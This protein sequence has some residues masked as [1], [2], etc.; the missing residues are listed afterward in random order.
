MVDYRELYE[1][2]VE[3]IGREYEIH[4]INCDHTDNDIDNLVM[5][6]RELHHRW[7]ES[8]QKVLNLS[9]L[10]QDVMCFLIPQ[11]IYK[12]GSGYNHWALG[13]MSDYVLFTDQVNDWILRRDKKRGLNP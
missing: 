13:I 3:P 12:G 8:Y 7:H 5:L 6:P 4:H 2:E 10:D 1:R 9:W 11:S